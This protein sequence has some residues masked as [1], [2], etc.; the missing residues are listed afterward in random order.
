MVLKNHIRLYTG[1][2]LFLALLFCFS[3]EDTEP[4]IINCAECLLY[5]PDEAEITIKLENVSSQELTIVKIY[6]GYL[7]DN[8]L[9]K[10]ISASSGSISTKVPFNK[11]YTVTATYFIDGTFYTAVDTF[12]PRVKYEEEQCVDPCYYVYDND[13]N[14]RL[15]YTE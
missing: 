4:L 15:K 6:T 9:Y 12:T 14:L 7:E 1:T 3:C 2:F 8:L 13:I 11:I 5:E 10:T